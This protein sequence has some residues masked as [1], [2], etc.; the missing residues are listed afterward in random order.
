MEIL[1]REV[2]MR[3]NVIDCFSYAEYTNRILQHIQS[4]VHELENYGQNNARLITPVVCVGKEVIERFQGE[5]DRMMRIE[6]IKKLQMATLSSLSMPEGK[7]RSYKSIFIEIVNLCDRLL[8]MQRRGTEEYLPLSRKDDII[9]RLCA[10]LRTQGVVGLECLT[11]PCRETNNT[12]SRDQ[13]EPAKQT[14]DDTALKKK[15]EGDEN[16]MCSICLDVIKDEKDE[17]GTAAWP[18]CSH[19]FHFHCIL[20]WMQKKR[21]CPLCRSGISPEERQA[22]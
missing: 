15:S 1:R 20:K 17:K 9:R 3:R 18:N 8:M 13:T 22:Q 4:I 10:T 5:G 21:N 7:T 19:R 16:S 11:T 14:S 6:L 2:V 12:A